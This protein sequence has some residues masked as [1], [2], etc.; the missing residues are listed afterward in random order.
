MGI[1]AKLGNKKLL[2]SC[3]PRDSERFIHSAH[4]SPPLTSLTLYGSLP[5]FH[6]VLPYTYFYFIQM[7][8]SPT[9][10]SSRFMICKAGQT[11]TFKQWGSFP[12]KWNLNTCW[13]AHFNWN[14][15]CRI[16]RISIMMARHYPDLVNN[17]SQYGI[18]EFV[19]QTSFGVAK[20]RLFSQATSSGTSD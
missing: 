5:E 16:S 17:A 4:F 10:P 6:E 9:T 3:W 15:C 11:G 7:D 14:G 1:N 12:R 13:T 20:R 2:A 19:S 8:S 18:P